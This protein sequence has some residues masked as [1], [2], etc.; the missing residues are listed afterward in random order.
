MSRSGFDFW[1]IGLAGLLL[2]LGGPAAAWAGSMGFRND[3]NLTLVVQ[4]I[5]VI[6]NQPKP[7]KPQKM[8]NGDVIRDTPVGAA[9]QRQFL[10][11]DA[12]NPNQPIYTGNFP[13]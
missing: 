11:F 1:K 6:N 8:N 3:T 12:K 5:V 10:I 4:E 13:C 9:A 2:A 7:G